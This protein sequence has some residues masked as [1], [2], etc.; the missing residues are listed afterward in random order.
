MEA[1]RSSR[2]PF[3]VEGAMRRATGDISVNHLPYMTLFTSS[4]TKNILQNFFMKRL[5]NERTN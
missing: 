3:T 4:A 5:Y 1:E 2:V